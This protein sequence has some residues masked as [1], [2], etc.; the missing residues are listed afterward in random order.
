MS[1]I[2]LGGVMLTLVRQAR[3]R[4]V[5][6]E[7]LSQGANTSCAALAAFILLLLAGTQVLNW[8]WLLPLPLASA[9]AG[10]WLALRS[11]PDR[12]RT[13]QLLDRRL[14][15]ADSLSTALHFSRVPADA[16]GVEVRRCQFA[17]AERL[18][19]EVDVR[20]AIPYT[21]PRRMYLLAALVVVASS[22]FAL[23]YGLSR[24]LDLKP[25]LAH[26]LRQQFGL[27]QTA[28]L[29]R[30][31]HSDLRSPLAPDEGEPPLASGQDQ[32]G[33][34]DSPATDA[35]D[36]QNASE[37]AAPKN[38]SGSNKQS[39]T[40]NQPGDDPEEAQAE[41]QPESQSG[42]NRGDSDRPAQ[43]STGSE[44]D[45]GRRESTNNQDSSLLSKMK[46]AFQNL[47]SRMKPQQG[48]TG[49]PEQSAMNQN[50][51]QPGKG[52]ESGGKPQANNAKADQQGDPS[53]DPAGESAQNQSDSQGKGSGKSDGKEAG[54]QPGSG[55]GSQD[56]DKRIKQAEQ[57][58]AM[59]KISEIIGKRSATIT[60][61]AT[62]EVQST[63][64]QI[65]T[66]YALH[67]AQH[68]QAGA[69][70]DRDEVPVGLESYVERYFEQLRTQPQPRKQP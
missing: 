41:A 70:I 54:K 25:P 11:A 10:I 47:L 28:A 30:N 21:L 29:A 26:I 22:L 15:L 8:F 6:N 1:E 36:P 62:V 44:Q 31:P 65:H 14:E 43:K 53:G 2:A 35:N 68:S 42:Q 4:L 49:S 20:R 19:H 39:S 34:G 64:Q 27:P 48:G 55:I 56:G 63:M 24:R 50:S 7:L 57:L 59:G 46:D 60:G 45:P 5:A 17:Q 12:Y 51:R 66:P 52:R 38:S 3:R 37:A 32:Q 23:R 69:Q 16:A 9:V 40:K 61:Q 58:A 13:A 67:N 33:S 18:A